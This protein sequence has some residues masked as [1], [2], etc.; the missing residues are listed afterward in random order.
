MT[1][2]SE[3]EFQFWTAVNVCGTQQV[4]LEEEWPFCS[5]RLPRVVKKG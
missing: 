5:D 3:E 2:I 4:T 1:K